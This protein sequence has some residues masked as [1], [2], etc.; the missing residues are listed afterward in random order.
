MNWRL[1]IKLNFKN[2]FLLFH[3]IKYLKPIQI[4]YRLYFFVRDRIRRWRNFSYPL[5]VHS[6][7]APLVLQPSIAALPLYKDN[8]FTFLNLS[9]QFEG[10]IDWNYLGYGKLWTYNLTYFDFL[11]QEGMCK[12]D[13]L[14]LIYDFTGQIGKI[15]DGLEPSPI[16]LR[17]IN[18]VKFLIREKIA[19][20]KIDDALYAQ[21]QI[22]MDNLEYHLLGN[23]LLE[24]G[25]SLLFGAYYFQNEEFYAKAEEILIAELKEQI[26]EDGAHFELSPMYHQIMLFR[27]L[28][29]I[30]LVQNNTYKAQ[31]LLPLLYEKAEVML[32][33]LNNITFQNGNIPLFNDS[34]NNIAPTTKQL[35]SYATELN[36]KFK[37]QNSKLTQSGYRK[38]N[39][40]HYEMII[41]V[42]NIG[43]DY[44]P[45]HAHSDTFN[46]ELYVDGKP[47]IVDTGI[48]SYE[49][50]ER[51]FFER[52]TAAHNTVEIDGRNQSEVW[53]SFRVADRAR[54]ISL[55][56][57][58]NSTI[59]IHDGY[60]KCLGLL[61]KRK[62]EFS[63][64]KIVIVDSLL[65][66]QKHKAIFRLH[67]H[68][69]VVIKRINNSIQVNN[70]NIL[71]QKAVVKIYNYQY[72]PKFNELKDAKMIEVEFFNEL[73][74]EIII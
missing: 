73:R 6:K 54:I 17:G 42:G 43:P 68:P 32:G 70:I 10:K 34:T 59:V 26:L 9:N 4:F 64:E 61:H 11:Q 22:L 48:S 55:K 1:V 38:Y 20:Q 12:E 37:I 7:S 36:S 16:S 21:Y 33:W 58:V 14:S 30:N 18:W 74:C 47:L 39:T 28:D 46:F 63:D 69:D 67:F 65:A 71:L 52:S 51:R 23:H 3:T 5:S 25:F 27:V 2:I 44:I 29:C 56:E 40:S 53:G 60:K 13:G 66:D 72:S 35:N 19:E 8:L 45:G 41:D 57:D 31:E 50:N 62:F 15:K 24:N 49:T